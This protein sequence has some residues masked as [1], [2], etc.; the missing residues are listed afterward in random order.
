MTP[1][2]ALASRTTA[3]A[4]LDLDR[5]A[6]AGGTLTLDGQSVTGPL[7]AS[8]GASAE[9]VHADGYGDLARIALAG[10][11]PGAFRGPASFRQAVERICECDPLD[12]G[13]RLRARAAGQVPVRLSRVVGSSGQDRA[14][15]RAS[16]VRGLARAGA[17]TPGDATRADP[18]AADPDRARQRAL[19]RHTTDP[20]GLLAGAVQ[21]HVL[22]GRGELEEVTDHPLLHLLA[23]PNP[24]TTT[25][26]AQLLDAVVVQRVAWG[27]VF[28]QHATAAARF[29]R[30]TGGHAPAEMFLVEDPS[31]VTVVLDGARKRLAGYDLGKAGAERHRS[32]GRTPTLGPTDLVHV[33]DLD[34]LCHLRGRTHLRSLWLWGE[35]Y[36]MA[37]RWN[38]GLIK[39]GA[40]PSGVLSRRDGRTVGGRQVERAQ[41]HAAARSGP[42]EAGKAW[43]D[44][45]LVWNQISLSPQD[46][47]W[48]GVESWAFRRLAG[49]VGVDPLL[50]GLG[51][52]STYNNVQ[53]AEARLYNEA[54]L[55]DLAWL[56]AGLNEGV[57]PL[58]SDDGEELV[59][60]A[61]PTEIPALRTNAL[62]LA[63]T[64]KS[65][66]W[67]TDG[68]KRAAQGYDYDKPKET[69]PP[70][71]A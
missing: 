65:S 66:D 64:L 37:G 3:G 22:E 67:L 43:V 32:G 8:L 29:A 18:S 19:G 1:T 70:N 13:L 42:D 30:R 61:D 33:K 57:V 40:K 50:L 12:V 14:R 38:A 59:L 62:D 46:M 25:T 63:K 60:W 48:P 47:D 2:T 24:L 71:N 27:E 5:F 26:W 58:L 36:L 56:L 6:A 16:L 7:A 41:A 51:E 23:H 55:P 9:V 21:M 54:A 44:G 35:M 20:H 15:A 39:N 45:E 28:A 53:S 68:E 49:G 4:P 11:A 34:P 10:G 31:T 17:L 52:H 69:T